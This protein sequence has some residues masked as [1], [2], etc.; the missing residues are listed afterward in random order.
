MRNLIRSEQDFCEVYLGYFTER[1]RSVDFFKAY[2][3]F[4]A[5]P[6]TLHLHSA[7][8]IGLTRDMNLAF[9]VSCGLEIACSFL[10]EKKNYEITK[11]NF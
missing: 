6:S 4:G 9:K 5:A 2:V 1:K 3:R 11:K 10:A 7:E 8:V